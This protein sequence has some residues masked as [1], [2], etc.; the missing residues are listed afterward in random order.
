LQLIKDIHQKSTLPI[1][2][3]GGINQ[4][5]IS[6]VIEAGAQCAAVISAVVSA[7][8]ITNATQSLKDQIER[9]VQRQL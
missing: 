9:V 2:A 3:I 8:N 5:N 4:T 7:P 1:V 6:S